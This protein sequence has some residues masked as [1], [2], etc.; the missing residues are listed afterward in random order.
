VGRTVF[1]AERRL[2][3]H[4]EV[5]ARQ[6]GACRRWRE[7]KRA[8]EAAARTRDNNAQ[9]TATRNGICLMIAPRAPWR[10]SPARW[11]RIPPV[12]FVRPCEPTLVDRPPAGADW[13]HE[14]K[15]D[16]FRILVR[17]LGERVK[18]WSRRKSENPWPTTQF[19]GLIKV[20]IR[21]ECHAHQPPGSGKRIARLTEKTSNLRLMKLARVAAA[22]CVATLIASGLSAESA[23]A[24]YVV[25]LRQVGSDVVATGNGPIDLTGLTFSFSNSLPA[26]LSPGAFIITG[27]TSPNPIEDVYMVSHPPP[28]FG[29]G[30]FVSIASSGSGDPVGES[31]GGPHGITGQLY[32]PA[33]YVSGSALSDS[34]TYDNQT[35][36]TLGVIPGTYE[37]TWGIGVNQNFTLDIGA[38][39]PEP[40]TW[41]MMVAGFAGLGFL[42]YR[43]TRSDNALA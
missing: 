9:L 6:R 18:V 38:A 34:A 29:S 28:P 24:G 8:L 43:K 32:V 27:P 30:N 11:T 1:G 15:H 4:P 2:P 25:T 23:M 14:V 19:W 33:G 37:W 17:K 39:V 13:L 36:S 41:A 21:R 35:F 31:V 10:A 22:F 26:L 3:Q 7:R 5:A 16:G 40:S 42:G 20:K 12:G